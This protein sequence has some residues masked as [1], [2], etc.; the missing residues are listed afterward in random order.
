MRRVR[1]YGDHRVTCDWTGRRFP[2]L[3]VHDTRRRLALPLGI[4]II[5]GRFLSLTRPIF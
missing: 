4:S 3:Q 1:L 2:S 5:R